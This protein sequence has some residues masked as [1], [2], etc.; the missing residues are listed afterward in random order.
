[1]YAQNSNDYAAYQQHQQQQGFNPNAPAFNYG[2][3]GGQQQQQ[4]AEFTP[5]PMNAAA[6][7]DQ[8]NV[9]VASNH[10]SAEHQTSFGSA[11]SN[12][13]SFSGPSTPALLGGSTK[14][15]RRRHNPYASSNASTSEPST[16]VV[17]P[18]VATARV[19]AADGSFF[20]THSSA[21]TSSVQS[22]VYAQ[23][24]ATGYTD[25]ASNHPIA[26]S[27][28]EQ[29][30]QARGTLAAA[31]CT[32]R[33][34]HM[35]VGA[36]RQQHTDKIQAIFEELAPHVGNIVMD[37]QGGHVIRTMVE[38]LNEQQVAGL[39][40]F[41]TPELVLTIATSS[42][43][44]RRVLQTLFERH[45]T[46]ALQPVVDVI[47]THAIAL[48]TTQQGC[49]A[50]MRC[51]EHSPDLHKAQVL[52]ALQP[53]L[54]ALTMDPYGNYVVQA[55]LQYFPNDV[56]CEVLEKAFAGHWIALSCNKFASNVME[57]FIQASPPMTRKTI[58]DELVHTAE[59]L[60]TLMQD[61]FGNFVLQQIIDTCT[62][63]TEYRKMSEKIRPL[64][65]VSPFGHKIEAKLKSKRFGPPYE[66]TSGSPTAATNARESANNANRQ[67]GNGTRKNERRGG[68]SKPAT[69]GSIV[70]GEQNQPQSRSVSNRS[71]S[72]GGA[73]SHNVVVA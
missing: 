55:V 33:G 31:A 24:V 7:A 48:S 60:G 71:S 22:P 64:L 38:F 51:M 43:N 50:V 19:P 30:A 5:Y 15:S 4:A 63:G 57:K 28:N 58:L 73:S 70:A 16:P 8:H 20:S 25:A 36:L 23:D 13:T 27:I 39:V 47:A 9:H 45:R 68:K 32:P 6:L 62:T 41:L 35:L 37:A 44:T 21:N 40:E 72:E 59:A 66:S 61:G 11:A 29:F 2:S 26:Y 34:R 49:I 69:D 42:Q 52:Q 18:A 56:A 67:A 53:Q 10:A 12:N 3:Y 46:P 14:S 65:T 1:M 54:A 17:G